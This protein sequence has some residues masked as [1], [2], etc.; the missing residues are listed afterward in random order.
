VSDK[1]GD[2]LLDKK[3]PFSSDNS[4]AGLDSYEIKERSIRGGTV[5]VLSQVISY[6]ITVISTVV[7]ARLLT[8]EDYGTISMVLVLISFLGLFRDLG[9]SSATIQS[10]NISHDQVSKLFWINISV[11]CL[12]SLIIIVISPLIARFYQKPNLKLVSII[13][14]LS[15]LIGSL[16]AQHEALLNRQMRFKTIAIIQVSGLIAGY[17]VAILL[18]LLGG[19]YW[20]L[21]IN[22]LVNVSWGTAGR[23]L[24]SGFR[25]GLPRPK[26]PVRHLISFGANIVTFDLFYYFRDH[27]D[28]ILIGRVW[29][30][31]QLGLY[32]KALSLL[33]LPFQTL[34]FP[35]SRV[36][37]PAMSHIAD[38][39]ERYRSY[40]IK[41][42][43]ILAFVS[44]P[45][46]CALFLC[47]KSLVII[48]LGERWLGVAELF[49]YLAPA[50]FIYSVASLR[51]TVIMSSGQGKRLSLWG[52]IDSIASICA[53]ICGIR[54]GAKGVAI[55]YSIINWLL[56]H[57]SL[58]FAFKNT[59][60]RTR[61]FYVSIIRPVFS[62]LVTSFVYIIAIKP[63]LQ[64]PDFF[65][66]AIT[67]PV[68]ALIY[69]ALFMILPGGRGNLIDFWNYSQ[70]L[71]K[72][73][74]FRKPPSIDPD[75]YR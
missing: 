63:F 45:L 7:L 2:Q 70:V 49:R 60:I 26:T 52:L 30:A 32:T 36:A 27:A 11:G 14:S 40:Y 50:A 29:G 1:R 38:R 62:S 21:V 37:F 69:L 73:S 5:T 9:L 44:M 54:W 15:Y 65:I 16:G 66:L 58:V 19:K 22:S 53:F 39:P 68:F 51:T 74:H 47:S 24:T 46:A 12:I 59:P 41:Y 25:P 75:I 34:R 61:D 28:Q 4:F 8:P 23:W 64:I 56:L 33:L 72:N 43:S 35:L 67:L 17:T 13:L 55:A 31:H 10:K 48:F 20:A 3:R 18:A 6:A 42:S 57:P 71:F